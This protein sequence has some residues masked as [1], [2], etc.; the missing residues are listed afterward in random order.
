M[1][2]HD[3]YTYYQGSSAMLNDNF[4]AKDRSHIEEVEIKGVKRDGL[5]GTATW[6]RRKT[7]KKEKIVTLNR[8]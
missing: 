2:A 5:R 6:E 7:L 3:T 8:N 4:T 1:P